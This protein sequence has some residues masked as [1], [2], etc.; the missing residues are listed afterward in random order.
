MFKRFFMWAFTCTA[1]LSVCATDLK[2]P[3]SLNKE[4]TDSITYDATLES[5]LDEITV[6]AKSKTTKTDRMVIIP[7]RN[8]VEA[9]TSGVDLLQR[10]ALPGISVNQMTGNIGLISGGILSLCI[11][12]VPA[13]SSQ[14][15]SLD[16]DDILRIEYH[17]CPG[18]K[19]GDADAVVDYITCRKDKV[20][21]RLFLESMNCIGNGK[22]A[23]LDE[24]SVQ[25]YHGKSV[26]SVNAGYA[27]MK[28]DNWIRD[29]EETWRYPDGEI[30][31][32]EKGLPVKVGTSM[33]GS[34]VNYRYV[35]DE[36]N[37]FNA[38]LSFS[39][40]DTPYKEEG[41]RHSFL[42]A[43]DRPYITEILE[44]TAEC[45]LRPSVS[46]YY[47]H[48][49]DNSRAISFDME[50]SWLHS[51]SNH[52]YSEKT[53]DKELCDI[54][55]RTEGDKYAIHVRGIYEAT[56]E[57]GRFTTG[58][59]HNQSHVSNSYQ[60]DRNG[61]NIEKNAINQSE[62]SIFAEYHLR[63]QKWGFT[64][65]LT[66]NRLSATQGS[67]GIIRYSV[68]PELSMSYHPDAECF[69]RYNLQFAHKL[70]P[71][72]S[73][74]GISQEIQPGM[75]RCGNPDVKSFSAISH[76]FTFSYSGKY[77]GVNLSVRYLDESKPVMNNV[78]Y[79]DGLFVQTYMNQKYFRKLQTECMISITPVRNYITL[80][81]TPDFSRYFSKGNNYNIV[82]NIFRIHFGADV[83]YRHFI[84]TA[85]TMSG[86]ENYMYGDEIITEKPMNM[87]LAGY[88]GH[89]WTLQAGA[90]NLMRNYWMKTENFS[91]LTPYKSEAHCGRNIY[92]AVKV[93]FNL[94]NG[95]HKK[96]EDIENFPSESS[97]DMDAGIVNGFK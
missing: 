24:I 1:A 15:A 8:K 4:I 69:V 70:P 55:A 65:A 29:Y 45:T 97:L 9:S 17:D 91:P 7:P 74:S 27:Q 49:F 93:S 75:I 59:M 3:D 39:Y 6:V 12:G 61:D 79:E 31:R 48:A 63:I 44:H 19:Y 60:L 83:E 21:G 38:R 67:V 13:S 51:Q 16:P 23:T 42:T 56:M 58:I 50:G 81:A 20:G 73:M 86:P 72:A 37:I 10:L 96:E 71:L 64:G 68:L 82:K 22:F 89:N 18:A 25:I 40:N 92:F 36:A 14:I 88:K 32:M 41:D 78:L 2:Y 35:H 94:N 80:W 33:L 34:E 52:T 77:A 30:V 11:N 26:W 87:I 54:F 76:G 28:R 57:S 46:L 43:S 90:F 62:S 47:R 85:C 5:L 84:F 95:K 53:A 66:G